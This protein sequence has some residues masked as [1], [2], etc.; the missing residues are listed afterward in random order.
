MLIALFCFQVK[1]Q[2][3]VDGVE[4]EAIGGLTADFGSML[5]ADAKEGHRYPA[6]FSE[7][8]TSCS[9]SSSKVI[10]YVSQILPLFQYILRLF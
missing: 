5:P 8:L 6:T 7:P 2:R 9:P 1:V 4:K 3:W 10:F